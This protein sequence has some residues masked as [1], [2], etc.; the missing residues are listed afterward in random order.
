MHNYMRMYWAK[1][2]LEWSRT[3]EQGYATA[4]RL[5]NRYFLDGRDPSSYA[6]VAWTFGLHDRPWPE[7]PVFGKVRSMT[8]GG[9][10]RK[11]DMAGYQYVVER[12]VAAEA[13]GEPGA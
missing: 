2:I 12:L 10:A 7:R 8:F 5:N 3:P 13:E 4:L 9:L 1:K 6:N 11:F